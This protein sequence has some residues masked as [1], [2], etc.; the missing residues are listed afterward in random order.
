MARHLFATQLHCCTVCLIYIQYS[1]TFFISKQN[2][3]S[4]K[5][6][7]QQKLYDVN[8]RAIYGSR[9]ASRHKTL[10]KKES[11]DIC[12]SVALLVYH[13]SYTFFTSKQID[14]SKENKGRQKLYDVNVRAIYGC[15]QAG[16]HQKLM[17]KRKVW[18]DIYNL[19]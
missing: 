16:R 14:L 6:K 13:I 5:N 12:Y 15:R 4:K 2:D 9:Q 7:G 11:F 3:L 18:L 19:R 1:H 17:K 10:L 8:V